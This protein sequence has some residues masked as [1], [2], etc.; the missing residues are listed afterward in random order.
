VKSR[1]LL[2]L[3]LALVVLL[4][5]ACSKSVG[6]DE[7]QETVRL[8]DG[9]LDPH[10]ARF[11]AW[12]RNSMPRIR[13]G[14]GV[15]GVSIAVI[16]Q[17]QMVWAAGYGW[18]DAKNAR[19]VTPETVFS[20]NSVSKSATAWGIMSLV[21]DGRLDLDAPIET[22]IGH[23]PLPSSAHDRRGVTARRLLSHT[24][25]ISAAGSLPFAESPEESLAGSSYSPIGRPALLDYAPGE[26]LYSDH[27]FTLLQLAIEGI[28]NQ[29]FSDFMQ[30]HVLDPLGVAASE[31]EVTYRLARAGAVG[32]DWSGSFRIRPITE[33]VQA[34]G[35]LVSSAA[36][37]GRFVA[38]HMTGPN[39][40]PQGRGVI[41]EQSVQL[42]LAPVA[43]TSKPIRFALTEDG[44][45][46][47]GYR[48]NTLPSGLSLISQVD[49]RPGWTSL[50]AAIPERGLGIVVLTNGDASR[51]R[52]YEHILCQWLALN[53]SSMGRPCSNLYDVYAL[54]LDNTDL[55]LL[56]KSAGTD[57]LPV[58]SADGGQIAF[59]RNA[60][61]GKSP[62]TYIVRT[63][64]SEEKLLSDVPMAAWA[65][66]GKRIAHETRR[67]PEGS[68]ICIT[69][70]GEPDCVQLTA[71][72]AAEASPAWSRDGA[73]I[74]FL[75][76]ATHGIWEDPSSW[77]LWVMNADGTLPEEIARIALMPNHTSSLPSALAWSPDGERIAFVAAHDIYIVSVEHRA[78]ERLTTAA[79]RIEIQHGRRMARGSFLLAAS[80]GSQTSS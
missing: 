56:T 43:D 54:N 10:V 29:S 11:T 4:G 23:W 61:G 47:M 48:V 24:S 25:G 66:D 36:D 3:T 12:L 55:T 72:D 9:Q 34:P 58:W 51:P 13:D 42:M 38:A 50:I 44:R 62:G 71:G 79:S 6:L 8:Y 53:G 77:D 39:L 52:L 16:D 18:A 60:G 5:G 21:E 49:N 78:V 35:G 7:P 28:S 22:Y 33:A 20:V 26:F 57:F 65:M 37:L 2:T 68:H 45:Y 76:S 80:R 27:N 70:I 59:S 64:G 46:A 67:F 74:A 41:S 19:P 63:D 30:S 17:G 75:R 14:Y 31:Y 32:E 15:P 69:A 40:E 73:R 1:L